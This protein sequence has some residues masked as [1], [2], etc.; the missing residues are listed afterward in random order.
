MPEPIACTL[1]SDQLERRITDVS[2]LGRRAL[3]AREP[4]PG[5]VRLVFDPAAEIEE[6][7]RALIAAEAE[8]CAFLRMELR[9]TAA[10]LRLDVTGPDEARPLID[11]LFD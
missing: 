1:S 2:A 4:I 9:A 7:L 3:R 11:G 6:E 5:G 8:C 10:G